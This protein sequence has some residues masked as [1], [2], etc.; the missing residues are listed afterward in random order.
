M[1]PTRIQ[2]EEHPSNIGI[3]RR[4]DTLLKTINLCLGH[5]LATNPED[6]FFPLAPSP[7]LFVGNHFHFFAFDIFIEFPVLDLAL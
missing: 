3:R 6:G 2:S 4:F 5:R 1:E 7:L